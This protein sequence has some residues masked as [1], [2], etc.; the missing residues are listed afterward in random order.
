MPAKTAGLPARPATRLVSEAGIDGEALAR[1]VDE[2][3]VTSLARLRARLTEVYGREADRFARAQLRLLGN[4]YRTATEASYP[5]Y[6]KAFEAYAARRV[7]PSARLAYIV[8]PR[9]PN[10]KDDP[11]DPKDLTPLARLLAKRASGARAELKA[12]DE[13][14]E[15]TTA[16]FLAEIDAKGDAAKAD[17]LAKIAKARDALNRQAVAEA[18]TPIGPRGE[19]AIRLSLARAGFARVPAVAARS[20]T[21]PPVPPPPPAPRV[22]SPKAL[23]DARARLLG[24]ARI[25]AAGAGLRLDPK[26]RDATSEFIR[27]KTLRAGASP[28]SPP[29]SAAP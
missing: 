23:A 24:E 19:S 15:A 29:F 17:V 6:R 13:E 10:P 9:D 11:V 12:L 2:A 1:E 8:G 20:L 14:F 16:A 18:L 26:G 22:E 7:V 4:P 21:L 5:A 28:N 25:W 3:Q 27:W